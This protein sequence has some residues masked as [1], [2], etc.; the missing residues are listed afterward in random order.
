M[1]YT[2]RY[3]EKGLEMLREREAEL[4]IYHVGNWSF[5]LYEDGEFCVKFD[6][7]NSDWYNMRDKED[8]SSVITETKKHGYNVNADFLKDQIEFILLDYKQNRFLPDNSGQVFSPIGCNGIIFRFSPI[9][10]D[11]KEYVC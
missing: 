11:S 8:F 9:T 6:Y 7:E 5:C 10:E 4:G 2:E 1:K 3:N